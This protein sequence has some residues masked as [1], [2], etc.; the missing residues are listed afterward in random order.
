[1]YKMTV[2]TCDQPQVKQ[3]DSNGAAEPIRGRWFRLSDFTFRDLYEMDTALAALTHNQCIISGCWNGTQPPNTNGN[4]T[5]TIRKKHG[6]T[7]TFEFNGKPFTYEIDAQVPY[8][9][10]QPVQWLCIDADEIPVPDLTTWSNP[11]DMAYAVW[12]Q[13]GFHY[14]QLQGV[15]ARWGISGSA[16]LIGKQHLAKFHFFILL[17]EPLLRHDRKKILQD[18]GQHHTFKA[19]VVMEQPSRRHFEAGR[20]F[21]SGAVDPLQGLKTHGVIEGGPLIVTAT[22]PQ[23]D[24]V[25]MP[26]M[27]IDENATTSAEGLDY[28]KKK[29]ASFG[30]VPNGE[31]HHHTNRVSSDIGSLVAG[32]EIAMHDAEQHLCQAVVDHGFDPSHH[33]AQIATGLHHGI[34]QHGP[35]TLESRKERSIAV[36]FANAQ[37]YRP[38]GAIDAKPA[39]RAEVLTD[40]ITTTTADSPVVNDMAREVATMKFADRK[41]IMQTAN[42]LNPTLGA[43]LAKG[44]Q[45]TRDE[46]SIDEAEA[47]Y[48]ANKQA[49]FDNYVFVEDSGKTTGEPVVYNKTTRRITTIPNFK[50]RYQSLEPY[51]WKS[52]DPDG[53]EV[54]K[55]KPATN[56]WLQF[57]TDK[58]MADILGFDPRRETR[59]SD[60]KGRRVFNTFLEP[61]IP[62]APGDVSGWADLV[63]FQVPDED[64]R[65]K[66]HTF[67]ALL[68]QQRGDPFGWAT[69][70][71]GPKGAG[72]STA[73]EIARLVTDGTMKKELSDYTLPLKASRLGLQ[74]NTELDDKLLSYIHEMEEAKGGNYKQRVDRA[75]TIKSLITDDMDMS[76]GKGKDAVQ[77]MRFFN[78]IAAANPEALP[79]F[80]LEPDERRWMM[81]RF[82]RTKEQ[83]FEKFGDDFWVRFWNWMQNGGGRAAVVHFYQNFAIPDHL[84]PRK[85]CTTAPKTTVWGDMVSES[86]SEA[87][88]LIVDLIE[89]GT[90]FGF[91]GG[92]ISTR[93]LAREFEQEGLKMPA[94]PGLSR[95]MSTF[96]YHRIGLARDC[97]GVGNTTLWFK[98]GSV[99]R[100]T[101][102]A[103]KGEIDQFVVAQSGFKR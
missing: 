100:P 35:S 102:R 71:V 30:N 17:S 21:M 77:T 13:Y 38:Q 103:L 19:D 46:I 92:W 55:R 4:V 90:C 86:R 59:Y 74:F 16:G 3:F 89:E 31:R 73:I 15:G 24:T 85:G 37:L 27:V 41:E 67:F 99:H 66:F 11:E 83:I 29:C 75:T 20:Q 50:M 60:Y 84:N 14:P 68:A 53:E 8:I 32:G 58:E 57:E 28:L 98:G 72:K 34:N 87:E 10:D 44:V 63:A 79:S 42:E 76:E 2:A 7:R 88:R 97:D 49:I 101:A 6:F 64:D 96:G 45:Q 39:T 12:Q 36:Q 33:F 40:M 54:V 62:S 18:L 91:Q 43:T 26:Q 78:V 80:L 5:L 94:G 81:I 93:A 56:F 82:E 70:I 22:E 61:N 51:V 25:E 69:G 65:L 48:E 47:A 23:P 9:A 1:M 95:I 52:I